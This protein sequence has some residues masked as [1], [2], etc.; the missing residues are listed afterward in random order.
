M[1]KAAVLRLARWGPVERFMTINGRRVGVGRFIAGDS[2]PDALAVLRRLDAD[3]RRGILDL[4]GE[5]VTTPAGAETE[6]DEIMA[7]LDAL[8]AEPYERQLSVKPTQ[9]GL[10][11]DPVLA[12]AHTRRIAARAAQVD[13]AVCLDMEDS[14]SVDATLELFRTVYSE[15]HH[16]LS[17]V[18]QAYLHRTPAD[19]DGLLRLRPMPALRIVKGAYLEP[20]TIAYQDMGSVDDAFRRLVFTALEAGS[21]VGIATHDEQLIRE[22]EAFIRGA[23]LGPDRY[24]FQMLY[25]VRPRLQQRLAAAGHTM[26]IYVPYGSD[27]YGYFSR[28]LAERPAN[29][30][31]LARS[32]LRP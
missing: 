5:F 16:H 22:T 13:A 32:L 18:V 30:L 31:F 14:G 29:L 28:R 9:L 15:E 3:G 25:G 21:Y 19:L 4:L 12:T 11:I 26:R 10:S 6:V 7:S 1:Y 23:G 27:W 17:T 20:A 24:E 2:L 8:A